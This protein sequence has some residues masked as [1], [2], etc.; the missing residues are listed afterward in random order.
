MMADVSH[1]MLMRRAQRAAATHDS[2]NLS[3]DWRMWEG[4]R[5]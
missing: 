4:V 1:A 2:I 3:D 5:G